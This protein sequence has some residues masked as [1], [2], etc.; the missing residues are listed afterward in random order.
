MA[1][2]DRSIMERIKIMERQALDEGNDLKKGILD[3]LIS[4]KAPNTTVVDYFFKSDFLE[5]ITE[6]NYGFCKMLLEKQADIAWFWLIQTSYDEKG[7]LYHEFCAAFEKYYINNV[8]ID[9]LQQIYHESKTVDSMDKKVADILNKGVEESREEEQSY[10]KDELNEYKENLLEEQKIF[11]GQLQE[12][13]DEL[14]RQFQV[15]REEK[16]AA[17]MKLDQDSIL[18]KIEKEKNS[19]LNKRIASLDS[20]CGHLQDNLR[21]FERDFGEKLKEAEK[22]NEFLKKALSEAE[23]REQQL[24]FKLDETLKKTDKPEVTSGISDDG[25]I[26]F[27]QILSEFPDENNVEADND[28]SSWSDVLPDG[29][30]LEIQD[31]IKGIKKRSSLF[32]KLFT[33]HHEKMFLQKP[34]MEQHNTIFIKMM[35]LSF[36]KDKVALVK[37]ILNSNTTLSCLELYKIVA[38]NPSMEELKTYCESVA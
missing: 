4:E 16:A 38:K 12:H 9:D 33:R 7:D 19:Q 27:E 37:E 26:G 36:E 22:E 28:D 35:E 2:D 13:N 15:I 3:L 8:D 32:S 29:E 10:K 23:Q 25:K 21:G 18:L 31:G 14:L 34:E 5:C 6:Q 11:I 1:E 20:I 24:I 17:Q 30:V